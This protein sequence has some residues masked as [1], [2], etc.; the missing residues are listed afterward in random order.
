MPKI[1][2][3]WTRIL[4]TMTSVPRLRKKRRRNSHREGILLIPKVKG[5]RKRYLDDHLETAKK[6]APEKR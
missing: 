4:L 6:R 5:V 1:W 3:I 2:N